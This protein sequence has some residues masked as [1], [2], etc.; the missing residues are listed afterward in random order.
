[1]PAIVGAAEPLYI[2]DPLAISEVMVILDVVA[3]A[4]WEAGVLLGRDGGAAMVWGR[5]YGSFL[6]GYLGAAE[7]FSIG[8]Q[9]AA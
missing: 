7:D 5:P 9:R 3:G 8:I 6:R 2:D 1:M 4:L